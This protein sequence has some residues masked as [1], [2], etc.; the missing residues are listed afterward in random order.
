VGAG[1]DATR[2]SHRTTHGSHFSMAR[3]RKDCRR[4]EVVSRVA[5]TRS[6]AW[7]CACDRSD[8]WFSG[9]GG[10][11]G[12]IKVGQ[13]A[14]L[15]VLSD[16]LLQCAEEKI[17]DITSVADVARGQTCARFRRLLESRAAAATGHAGLVACQSLWRLS[18]SG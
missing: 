7:R 6:R 5:D 8:T 11:K 16:D 1:T 13:L 2:V 4:A 15:A 12:Q 17:E 3:H 10:K 18:E 9:E 14:D